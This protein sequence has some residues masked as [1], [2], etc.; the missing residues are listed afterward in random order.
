MR[1]FCLIVMLLIAVP[2]AALELFTTVSRSRQSRL[3]HALD[4][5][6][7]ISGAASAML[8]EWRMDAVQADYCPS[9]LTRSITS[10][11]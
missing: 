8:G 3:D 5:P 4:R 10:R 1:R 6:T 7:S 2:F 11:G 9:F